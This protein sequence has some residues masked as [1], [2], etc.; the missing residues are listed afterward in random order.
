MISSAFVGLIALI[1]SFYF[2]F[3]NI[4]AIALILLMIILYYEFWEYD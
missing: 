3:W 1:I 4:G 2:K